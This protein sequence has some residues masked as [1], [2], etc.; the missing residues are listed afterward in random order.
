MKIHI[1]DLSSPFNT[2]PNAIEHIIE[3]T[4]INTILIVMFNL[5]KNIGAVP[6]NKPIV[7]SPK[8]RPGV[9]FKIDTKIAKVMDI[10][11]EKAITP[12]KEII[13]IL[14]PKHKNG[15]AK[16]VLYIATFLI[17]KASLKI[18]PRALPV[19]IKT[20]S[21][22]FCNSVLFHDVGIP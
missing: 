2:Y 1:H 14:S 10:V 7:V 17:P 13:I 19:P 5:I 20:N 18:P 6:K 8:A 3:H 16:S 11:I 9:F 12:I 4:I 22:I 15:I 21:N